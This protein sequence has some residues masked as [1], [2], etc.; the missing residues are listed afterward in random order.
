M[1]VFNFR[2]AIIGSVMMMMSCP[3]LFIVIMFETGLFMM[4]ISILA[5]GK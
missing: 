2:L 5:Q 3:S 4:K 1:R